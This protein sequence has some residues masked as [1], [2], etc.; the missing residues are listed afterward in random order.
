MVL[1]ILS[2]LLTC[3]CKETDDNI[4]DIPSCLLPT[5]QA[6]VADQESCGGA[7][8]IAYG[9][10]EEEVFA[11]R[12]GICTTDSS[13]AIYGQDCELICSFGGIDDPVDCLGVD[14]LAVAIEVRVIWQ[15]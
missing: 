5:Y 10:Q 13:T 8:V 9:Y 12:E 14:F 1:V 2:A 7:A 3:G 11:M 4:V 15:G 6:F